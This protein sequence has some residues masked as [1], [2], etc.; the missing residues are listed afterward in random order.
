MTL[1]SGGFSA[2]QWALDACD[3]VPSHRVLAELLL[4]H[5]VMILG[6]EPHQ[7]HSSRTGRSDR[8]TI[9]RTQLHRSFYLVIDTRLPTLRLEF[10]D[11]E[12]R[13]LGVGSLAAELAPGTQWTRKREKRVRFPD[14]LEERHRAEAIQLVELVHAN[15]V[16]FYSR[17]K[18]FT[19]TLRPLFGKPAGGGEP[20]PVPDT[21]TFQRLLATPQCV[22]CGQSSLL[23]VVR[24]PGGWELRC[25]DHHPAPSP[26][27][28]IG[29][30]VMPFEARRTVGNR[31]QGRC[32]ACGSENFLT[33]D[34]T[35]PSRPAGRTFSGSNC[36]TICG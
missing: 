26:W 32:V 33:F 11:K 35:I 28:D 4:D 29:R 8:Q 16:E 14:E 30:V 19:E 13:V 1:P 25:D 2:A 6:S 23:S 10:P 7:R 27:R 17:G 15:A 24:T 36:E 34:H 3:L 12:D 21:E 18:N 9:L 5:A 31:D 22:G 20:C